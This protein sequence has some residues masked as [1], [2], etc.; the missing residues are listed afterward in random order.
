MT[1]LG[2]AEAGVDTKAIGKIILRMRADLAMPPEDDTRMK[3][4]LDFAQVIQDVAH[5]SSVD[6]SGKA[7][8]PRPTGLPG[9]GTKPS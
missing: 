4:K 3:A 6:R 7:A 1:I 9:T 5:D 8:Q 2:L